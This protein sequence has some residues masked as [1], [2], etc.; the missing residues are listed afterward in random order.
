V[1]PFLFGDEMKKKFLVFALCFVAVSMWAQTIYKITGADAVANTL[2]GYFAAS[3]DGTGLLMA[4]APHVY[5]GSTWDRMRSDPCQVNAKVYLP[6]SLTA[7]TKIVTGTASK[8][9]YVCSINLVV[10]AAT[11]VALVEGTGSTCG[12]NT[13]GMAGGATAATGWNFAANGGL[14]QGNGWASIAAQATAADD[15]CIFVS[16]AN[17]T[18]GTIVYVVAS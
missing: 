17:Q 12:T 13:A 3:A 18:S 14:T 15:L 10:A 9:I 7:N 11:N 16:A 1:R 8:K 4:T 6:V 2:V 5:N